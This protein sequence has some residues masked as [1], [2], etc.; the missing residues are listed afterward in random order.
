M[1]AGAKKRR[2]TS[3]R[4]RLERRADATIDPLFAP[5]AA[6]FAKDRG[7][8]LGRMFSSSSVLNV[9]GKMFAM[10]VKGKFVAKLPRDRVADLVRSGVGEHFDPGHGRL[11][12]EWVAVSGASESW[13]ALAR[14]AHTFVKEGRR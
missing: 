4:P 10:L 11:M 3:A 12:K 14:E 8:G 7:V 6:A 13:V 1:T 9:G 2:R 5:V